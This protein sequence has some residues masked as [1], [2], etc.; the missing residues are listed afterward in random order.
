MRRARTAR[1]LAEEFGASV[2]TI[3]RHLAEPRDDYETR[4]AA[5]RAR[6]QQLRADGASYRQIADELEVSIG[7]VSSLL[8]PRQQQGA[9]AS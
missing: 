3:Q 7:S 9:Q 4:A 5:K 6:A 2:R 1:E 8:Y